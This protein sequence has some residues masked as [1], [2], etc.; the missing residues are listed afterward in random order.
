MKL[1]GENNACDTTL[2]EIRKHTFSMN[3]RPTY[4][5]NPYENWYK[6][7]D[8]IWKKKL[9]HPRMSI[10]DLK[11]RHDTHTDTHTPIFKE[12]RRQHDTLHMCI[13]PSAHLNLH[14]FLNHYQGHVVDI[15]RTC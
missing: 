8:I 4:P 7:L 11:T 12:E 13:G 15:L 6:E 9:G 14:G 10:T 2:V 3:S 5:H 1:Y